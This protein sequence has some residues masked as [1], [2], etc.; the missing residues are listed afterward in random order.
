[1]AYFILLLNHPE[2]IN[3]QTHFILVQ[4]ALYPN[5]LTLHSPNKL[6]PASP[7]KKA[8]TYVS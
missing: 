1:M 7:F 5:S 2:L 8:K 3:T 4:M 6:E